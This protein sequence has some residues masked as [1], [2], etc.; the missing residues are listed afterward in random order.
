MGSM[1]PPKAEGLVSSQGLNQM[2]CEDGVAMW[3]ASSG[4]ERACTQAQKAKEVKSDTV[5]DLKKRTSALG[6]TG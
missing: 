3:S 6:N 4:D 1:S 5:S 2:L